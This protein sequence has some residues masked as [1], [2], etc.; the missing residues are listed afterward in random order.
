MSQVFIHTPVL[1]NG[2]TPINLWRSQLNHSSR[3]WTHLYGRYPCVLLHWHLLSTVCYHLYLQAGLIAHDDSYILIFL[4][5][6]RHNI[7]HCGD[8]AEGP[9][10][11]CVLLY[12][13][14]MIIF[15][16]LHYFGQP[17]Q[18]FY[19]YRL[20]LSMPFFLSPSAIH[21]ST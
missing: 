9:L 3:D 13:V 17:V 4:H 10:H 20:P 16:Q 15:F 6:T 11:V 8:R 21:P 1:Q 12:L 7:W 2:L 19:S 14:P 5:N 18:C